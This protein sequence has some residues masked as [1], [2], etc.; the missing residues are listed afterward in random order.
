MLWEALEGPG[1]IG[2]KTSCGMTVGLLA[3]VAPA[4]DRRLDARL[5]A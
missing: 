1:W 3:G 2:Q 5:A 4:R